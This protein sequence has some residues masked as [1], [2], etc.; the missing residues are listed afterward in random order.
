[1]VFLRYL[2]FA[3]LTLF[4][5]GGLPGA[6][7]FARGD[8]SV[9]EAALKA[10]FVY[11]FTRFVEWPEAVSTGRFNLCTVGSGATVEALAAFEGK[12]AWGRQIHVVPASR[13][14]A[15][16]ACQLIFVGDMINGLAEVLAEV[17]HSATLTV[18]EGA[19][20]IAQGGLIALVREGER[21]RFE[22]DLGSAQSR[23][24][25]F[26]APLLRLAKTVW[27]GH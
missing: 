16:R 20:F 6:T 24:L 23:G 11:N 3:L 12:M 5:A 21:L 13:G 15:L 18:G 4:L 10:A 8:D 27:N 2:H 7:G 1:M 26:G 19:G 14:A 25:K 9:P 17:R 22:V